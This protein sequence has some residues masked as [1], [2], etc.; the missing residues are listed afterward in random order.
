MNSIII[1]YRFSQIFFN[2]G[3][4]LYSGG[5]LICNKSL[6]V[7]VKAESIMV[8][9][10]DIWD[11]LCIMLFQVLSA[12]FWTFIILVKVDVSSINIVHVKICVM[13]CLTVFFSHIKKSPCS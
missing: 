8:S 10:F 12:N 5:S 1:S 13:R 9:C 3:N 11:I 2:V 6:L 4:L 7:S